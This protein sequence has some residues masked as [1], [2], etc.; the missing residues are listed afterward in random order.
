MSRIPLS[1]ETLDLDDDMVDEEGS[2]GKEEQY[3]ELNFGEDGDRGEFAPDTST[4]P[5]FD[6][7]DLY[8]QDDPWANE[9]P[10]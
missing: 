7:E 2:P 10:V 9:E 1:D 3:A 5:F 8:I 4:D 6:D